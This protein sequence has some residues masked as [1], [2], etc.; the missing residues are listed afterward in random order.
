MSNAQLRRRKGA[1]LG[2]RRL[3][4]NHLHWRRIA[5]PSFQLCPERLFGFG[6]KILR[7][8]AIAREFGKGSQLRLHIRA[9]NGIPKSI[10]VGQQFNGVLFDA[11]NL[12]VRQ[13]NNGRFR[14]NCDTEFLAQIEA[15]FGGVRAM[16]TQAFGASGPGVEKFVLDFDRF[17]EMSA[18][19]AIGEVCSK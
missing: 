14:R 8:G 5:N 15:G 7:S 17:R 6:R 10:L 9:R 18:N 11:E 2:P 1:S 13:T 12:C 4:K 19:S 3:V 16:Q